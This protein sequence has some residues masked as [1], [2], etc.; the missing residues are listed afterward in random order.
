[1]TDELIRTINLTKLYGA[2]ETTV[3]ALDGVNL[4]VARGELLAVMGPSGCGKSTLLN[5]LGALD[6]PTVGRGLGGGRKPGAAQASWT[7]SG[8]GRSALSSSFTTCCRL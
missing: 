6:Q 4:S 7:T 5:M 2:G 3:R 1:M 8:R